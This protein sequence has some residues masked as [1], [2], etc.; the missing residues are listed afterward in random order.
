[1]AFGNNRAAKQPRAFFRQAGGSTISF[2]HPFLAGQ[3]DIEGKIDE[4]DISA[5]CKLDG[6]YFEATQNMDSAKQVVL[7][8]S[9]VATITNTLLNGTI[10]LPV[11]RTTGLVATGDFVSICQLIRASGDSVGGLL[12]KTDYIGGKALT[13]LFYGVT[14]QR[15]PDDVSEGND[16]AVYNIQLLYSG[17]IE[18][19]S[20]S[21]SENRKKIWAVGTQNGVQAVFSPYYYQNEN[22]SGATK[23][24]PVNE[25]NWG[26]VNDDTAVNANLASNA[27]AAGG[28]DDKFFTAFKSAD[29]WKS[30]VKNGDVIKASKGE[31]ASSVTTTSPT[32]TTSS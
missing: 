23:D 7:V 10:T 27:D 32:T 12:Y 25:N 14:V 11:V 2:R 16:V 13:K 26:G 29:G 31:S 3:L 20:A 1:M 19:L 28:E 8:D 18:A 17:W 24:E 30:V 22:G 21:L 9:S 15:C 5:C 6:R 4:V